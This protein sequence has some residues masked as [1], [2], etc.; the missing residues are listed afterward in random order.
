M[1]S[2]CLTTLWLW[3]A[4]STISQSY[5]SGMFSTHRAYCSGSSYILE[6]FVVAALGKATGSST[7][8]LICCTC[9]VKC[10]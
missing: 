4:L 3:A 9:M 10:I 1:T 8:K 6:G 7:F 5:S 2:A